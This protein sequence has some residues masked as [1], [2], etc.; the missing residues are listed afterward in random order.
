MGNRNSG[1][2][3]TAGWE[4]GSWAQVHGVWLGQG[5]GLLLGGSFAAL[6]GHFPC[7]QGA[8]AQL[9]NISTPI[10]ILCYALWGGNSALLTS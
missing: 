3:G 2:L 1:G 6:T 9:R 8:S 5:R 4:V 10:A 7:P